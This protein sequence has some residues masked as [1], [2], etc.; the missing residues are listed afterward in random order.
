MGREKDLALAG[1]LR[2][3]IVTLYNIH[4]TLSCASVA[5]WLRKF[6]KVFGVI[7]E[8]QDGTVPGTVTTRNQC[9]FML[10]SVYDKRG[11]ARRSAWEGFME[12]RM[13][14]HGAI[15]SETDLVVDEDGCRDPVACV[16]Y[17]ADF[18]PMYGRVCDYVRYIV[19][20]DLGFARYPLMIVT[21]PPVQDEAVRFYISGHDAKYGD[22]YNG[23]LW[24]HDGGCAIV[25]FKEN[26]PLYR[27]VHGMKK[28]VHRGV[29]VECV[30]RPDAACSRRRR[31]PLKQQI[32]T[33]E[34]PVTVRVGSTVA[35]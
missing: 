22:A 3:L 4:A 29:D 20:F 18:N 28:L 10:E 8:A 1:D 24:R 33:H 5:E 31:P 21:W 26:A 25:T 14:L 11:I 7:L 13:E 12:L 2:Q 6:G 23:T 19:R 16:E 35:T 27:A 9:T 15:A 34:F 32:D 17:I 30:P